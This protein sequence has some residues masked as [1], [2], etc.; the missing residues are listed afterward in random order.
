MYL[1][2]FEKFVKL[3]FEMSAAFIVLFFFL[4]IQNYWNI[5]NL[6]HVFVVPQL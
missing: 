5:V 1:N 2:L 4:Q 3:K 6:L